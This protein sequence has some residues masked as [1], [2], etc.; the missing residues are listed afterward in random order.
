MGDPEGEVFGAAETGSGDSGIAEVG[1][2]FSSGLSIFGCHVFIARGDATAPDLLSEAVALCTPSVDG[3][4]SLDSA[5]RRSV[6]PGNLAGWMLQMRGSVR[7]DLNQRRE[8][9]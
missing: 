7:L 3:R 6:A 8:E 4:S 1:G 2:S 9:G 5:W